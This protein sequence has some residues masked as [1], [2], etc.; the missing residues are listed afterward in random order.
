MYMSPIKTIDAISAAPPNLAV[1]IDATVP[2]LVLLD[3]NALLMPFQ[4]SIH[5]DAELRR[6]LGEVE[7]AVPEPVLVELEFLS[8]RDRDAKA[9]LRL[10]RKYRAIPGAGSADDA[11]L[12]LA[13]AHHA[14]V[15]TN[16][17]PLLDRLRAAGVPRVSL[18]S[19]SH[20]VVDGL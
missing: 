9:A 17:Q 7:V 2:R 20:L 11:I 15:V 1:S 18:R 19:R 6:L 4:F 10:A 12:E 13:A 8:E 16:D 3:S 14:V 5:L